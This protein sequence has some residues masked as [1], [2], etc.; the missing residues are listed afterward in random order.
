MGSRLLLTLPKLLI[1]Q[2][3]ENTPFIL[4]RT[5]PWPCPRCPPNA[6]CSSPAD[7]SLPP[8]PRLRTPT[9]PSHASPGINQRAQ[10]AFDLWRVL[11]SSREQ[12]LVLGAGTEPG[13]QSWAGQR[14]EGV[15]LC[16]PLL[17][18]LP[19]LS[20]PVPDPDPT[21]VPSLPFSLLPEHKNR[22]GGSYRG[23]GMRNDTRE[24]NPKH[25]LV[26]QEQGWLFLQGPPLLLPSR[27]NEI[28]PC[29]A[30]L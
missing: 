21:V 13:E 1:W 11:A 25:P 12:Q 6:N 14:G 22:P 17:P 4:P 10:E 9:T 18:H 16:Q 29:T 23:A 28:K 19:P 27:K 2:G 26:T 7:P 8:S 5:L 24:N 15:L 30:P 20:T 3:G